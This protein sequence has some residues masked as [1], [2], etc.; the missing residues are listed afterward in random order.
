M[1]ADIAFTISA[2]NQYILSVI[3]HDFRICSV[4]MLIVNSLI[5]LAVKFFANKQ[6]FTLPLARAI[7]HINQMTM[8][9]QVRAKSSYLQLQ[10]DDVQFNLRDRDKFPLVV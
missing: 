10:G 1:D 3:N 5:K 4:S 6:F 7:G 9:L 8:L 2:N